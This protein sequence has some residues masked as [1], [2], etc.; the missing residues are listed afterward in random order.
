MTGSKQ[1]APAVVAGAGGKC[2][3]TGYFIRLKVA[4]RISQ[5]FLP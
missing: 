3:A 2:F 4:W 1:K 5:S